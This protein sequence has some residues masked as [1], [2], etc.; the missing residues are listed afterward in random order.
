MLISSYI[1]RAIQKW[2]WNPSSFLLCEVISSLYSASA[3]NHSLLSPSEEI[4]YFLKE[5]VKGKIRDF[6]QKEVESSK[7]WNHGFFSQL[8]IATIH[9]LS[10]LTYINQWLHVRYIAENENLIRPSHYL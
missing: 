7:G 5:T 4:W 10:P 6:A 3:I 2:H 1:Y 9:S 8:C